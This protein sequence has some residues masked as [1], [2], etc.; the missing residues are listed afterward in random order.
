LGRDLKN[1]NAF[2]QRKKRK[3]N[4][5][6]LRRK[7]TVN[8]CVES[9]KSAEKGRLDVNLKRW[10]ANKGDWEVRI[11]CTGGVGTDDDIDL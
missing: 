1:P 3:H 5:P 4:K 11:V 2:A 10:G 9:N 6:T 7:A 8:T